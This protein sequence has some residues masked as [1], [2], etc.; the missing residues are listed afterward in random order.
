M[1]GAV[2]RCGGVR[3]LR[4]TLTYAWLVESVAVVLYSN[5]LFIGGM[6]NKTPGGC[7]VMCVEL[8]VYRTGSTAFVNGS[9]KPK[10]QLADSI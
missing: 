1:D 8:F 9:P 4:R 10:S 3:D 7:I 2:A 5:C 6:A